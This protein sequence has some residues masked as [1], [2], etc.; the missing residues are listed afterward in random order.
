MF[1]M[2]FIVFLHLLNFLISSYMLFTFSI[3][4]FS[5]LISYFKFPDNSN[6]WVWFCYLPCLRV[7][8]FF[9]HFFCLSHNFSLNA[10]HCVQA[11]RVWSQQCLCLIFCSVISGGGWV[12]L[13]RSWAGVGFQSCCGCLLYTI[14]KFLQHH[15]V[16][17]GGLACLRDFLS[18]HAHSQLTALLGNL[19]PHFHFSSHGSCCCSH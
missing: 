14:C 5:T 17:V 11:G 16:P 12:N 4:D 7:I 1:F 19:S 10:K 2:S 9:S 6:V 8:D 18:A 15:L 13:V 3:R